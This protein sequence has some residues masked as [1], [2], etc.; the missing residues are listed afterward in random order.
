M[1]VVCTSGVGHVTLTRGLLVASLVSR[2]YVF[3]LATVPSL[4]SSSLRRRSFRSIVLL[5][6]GGSSALAFLTAG[7]LAAWA[8]SGGADADGQTK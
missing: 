2:T 6:A 5:L 8:V 4:I 1:G 7:G 3:A